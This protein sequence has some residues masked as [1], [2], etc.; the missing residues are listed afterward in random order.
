MLHLSLA[1]NVVYRKTFTVSRVARQGG[2]VTSLDNRANRSGEK[3]ANTSNEEGANRKG[4]EGV[5]AT[6]GQEGRDV[7]LEKMAVRNPEEKASRTARQEGR[8]IRLEKGAVRS[9]EEEASRAARHEGRGITSEENGSRGRAEEAGGPSK[10]FQLKRAQK[11]TAQEQTEVQPEVISVIAVEDGVKKEVLNVM[12]ARE[13]VDEK[14]GLPGSYSDSQ[15]TYLGL[16]QRDGR[17]RIYRYPRKMIKDDV[18]RSLEISVNRSTLPVNVPAIADLN[19]SVD[20]V[21]RDTAKETLEAIKIDNATKEPLDYNMSSINDMN[22]RQPSKDKDPVVALHPKEMT[23]SERTS[24]KSTNISEEVSISGQQR[25][26]Q[27]ASDV[28]TSSNIPRPSKAITGFASLSKISLEHSAS[29]GMHSRA[30]H[31]AVSEENGEAFKL[32][33]AP[34]KDLSSREQKINS[35]AGNSGLDTVAKLVRTSH[36]DEMSTIEKTQY[37]TAAR[38]KSDRT[39]VQSRILSSAVMVSVS[40]TERITTTST[41]EMLRMSTTEKVKMSTTEGM[42]M[43]TTEDKRMSTTEGMKTYTTEGVR[44][45]T[46]EGIIMP[47]TDGMKK[48]TAG[49]MSMSVTEGMMLSTEGMRMSATEKM[50]TPSTDGM[51][52]STTEGMRM[53]ATERTIMFSTEGIKVSTIVEM[54]TPSTDGMKES[55]TEGMRMS[56][57]EEMRTPSTDGI[58]EATEEGMRMSATEGTIMLSTEGM[59]ISTSEEMRTISTDE[60]RM[61]TIEEMSPS[62]AEWMT[63]S[64][65]ERMGPSPT[66]WMTM[67]TTD[68]MKMSTTAETMTQSASEAT[69]NVRNKESMNWTVP[70]KRNMPVILETRVP[71]AVTRNKSNRDGMNITNLNKMDNGLEYTKERDKIGA[72]I[73]SPMSDE[74]D[75]PTTEMSHMGTGGTTAEKMLDGLRMTASKNEEILLTEESKNRVTG[76]VSA[77]DEARFFHYNLYIFFLKVPIYAEKKS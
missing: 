4:Q 26:D 45:F 12:G 31:T 74:N 59:R 20:D 17:S 43:S 28:R 51:K 14:R 16:L 62:A 63:I 38:E 55:T 13:I 76:N 77:K 52:E 61:S 11:E 50:R 70:F 32:P 60:M 27:R 66:E 71:A 35:T 57:I 6:A 1:Q 22:L 65:T 67:P 29:V 21:K 49:G 18:E 40:T 2:Q 30:G 73:G 36:P 33:P 24:K 8:D 15:K 37:R 41:K 72:M 5:S 7:R 75:V 48:S 25:K 69:T 53:S 58:E 3:G 47:A 56:S 42:R 19:S 9:P 23:G 44:S 10:D 54:R 68:R 46:T 64:T 39:D 34:G